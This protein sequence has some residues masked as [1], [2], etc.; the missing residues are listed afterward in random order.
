MQ[1]T[2]ERRGFAFERGL[3]AR[4]ET[5]VIVNAMRHGR[6]ADAAPALSRDRRLAATSALLSRREVVFA[7]YGVDEISAVHDDAGS[8]LVAAVFLGDFDPCERALLVAPGSHR[9]PRPATPGDLEVYLDWMASGRELEMLSGPA[10][11]VA[12]LDPRLFFMV[13]R[14][15]G[16]RS[17]TI[18]FLSYGAARGN[19]PWLDEAKLWPPAH[20]WTAG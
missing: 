8:K 1:S 17:R 4:E 5:W 16:V 6:A 2:F 15:H 14:A 11:S 13:S 19:G 20:A 10:G 18:L 3:L 12:F 7:G 9:L